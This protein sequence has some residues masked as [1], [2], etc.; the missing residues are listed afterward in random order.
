MK[1]HHILGSLWLAFCSF[2]VAAT[3]WHLKQ[4]HGIYLLLSIGICLAY[5]AGAVASL[6]LFRGAA[7]ARIMIASLALLALFVCFAQF[8]AYKSP[9]IWT[10]VVGVFA[11]VSVILLLFPRRYV[12]A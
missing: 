1:T 11:L 6:F 12:A 7:W 3:L 8:V 4:T 5:L 2:I 9:T 10:G